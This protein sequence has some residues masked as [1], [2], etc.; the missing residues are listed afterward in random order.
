[1]TGV[2]TATG[3]EVAVKFAAVAPTA[4]V[5]E[6]GTVREGSELVRLTVRPAG[7]GLVNPMVPTT[8]DPPAIE[9]RLKVRAETVAADTFSVAVV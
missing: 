9:G 2:S 6:A 7:A 1:M 8:E 5:T 4:N 3:I